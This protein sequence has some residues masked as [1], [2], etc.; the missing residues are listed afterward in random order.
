MKTLSLYRTD[1]KIYWFGAATNVASVRFGNQLAE[2]WRDISLGWKGKLW[3]G[4]VKL[5]RGPG[6]A[7]KP[8]WMY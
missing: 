8:A 6:A 7:V 1:F 2:R 3:L 4:K 5:M